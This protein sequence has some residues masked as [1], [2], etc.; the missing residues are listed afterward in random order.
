MKW[1]L[2]S[3]Q[4]IVA[5][6]SGLYNGLLFRSMPFSTLSFLFPLLPYRRQRKK[7]IVFPGQSAILTVND[8]QINGEKNEL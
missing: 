4:D 3:I 1:H 8:L 7:K 2:T 6:L 5:L